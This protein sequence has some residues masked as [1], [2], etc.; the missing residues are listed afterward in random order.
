MTHYVHQ[1]R[2]AKVLPLPENWKGT[3]AGIDAPTTMKHIAENLSVPYHHLRKMVSE[4]TEFRNEIEKLRK[5]KL[6]PLT[7]GRDAPLTPDEI[8]DL[9]F[10]LMGTPRP[11]D[12][13]NARK[14]IRQLRSEKRVLMSELNRAK[15]A[16]MVRKTSVTNGIHAHGGANS[17]RGLERSAAPDT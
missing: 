2:P 7:S 8:D 1:N 15:Y 10:A 6:K 17:N 3:L 16:H 12:L 14:A 11:V 4:H 5:P 13:T 9:I